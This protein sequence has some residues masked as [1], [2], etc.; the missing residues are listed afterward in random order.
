MLNA[1]VI[2]HS[3]IKKMQVEWPTLGIQQKLYTALHFVILSLA[4]EE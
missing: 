3:S 2:N 4:E 1:K